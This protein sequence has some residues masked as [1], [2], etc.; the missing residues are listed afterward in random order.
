MSQRSRFAILALKDHR[1]MPAAAAE[2]ILREVEAC[3]G[4]PARA[5]HPVRLDENGLAGCSDDAR[6]V[7][8]GTPEVPGFVD[9][10]L[11]ERFVLQRQCGDVLRGEDGDACGKDALECWTP[12]RL[13]EAFLS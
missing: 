13:H 3:I 12:D 11:M 2:Q 4:E 1:G 5:R 8:H 7:P 9:R 6:E 10:P